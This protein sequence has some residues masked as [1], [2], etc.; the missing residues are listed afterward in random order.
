MNFIPINRNTST[1][2]EFLII[3]E[4]QYDL[5]GHI[6]IDPQSSNTEV[7]NITIEVFNEDINTFQLETAII[8]DKV[9]KNNKTFCVIALNLLKVSG[10][11]THKKVVLSPRN[12]GLNSGDII[13]FYVN[14]Y[15]KRIN[16]IKSCAD[17]NL[18]EGDF[19]PDHKNGNIIIGNP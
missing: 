16:E 4:E 10:T 6:T 9:F 7:K 3:D 13:Y 15:V 17:L 19:N 2:Q 11:P 14:E 18:F 1:S 8:C 5:K 12:F